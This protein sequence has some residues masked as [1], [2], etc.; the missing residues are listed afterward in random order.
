TGSSNAVGAHVVITLYDDKGRVTGFRQFT[1]PDDQLVAGGTTTFDVLV[2][3]DPS[4][5]IVTNSTIVA[6]ART[7]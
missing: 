2:S 1:L 7:R 5:P 4:A 3:P 6:Q